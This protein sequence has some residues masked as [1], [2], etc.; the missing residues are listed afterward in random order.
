M[1]LAQII[2]STGMY[3][4]MVVALTHRLD[5]INRITLAAYHAWTRPRRD[6]WMMADSVSELG[7]LFRSIVSQVLEPL[8]ILFRE[9]RQQHEEV[10]RSQ[11]DEESIRILLQVEIVIASL[12]RTLIIICE[13]QSSET[14]LL[15][16]TGLFYL[17]VRIFDE[18]LLPMHL[19]PECDEDVVHLVAGLLTL[20]QIFRTLEHVN[21]VPAIQDQLLS[22]LLVHDMHSYL[23]AGNQGTEQEEECRVA[24]QR[25]GIAFYYL[26]LR[27][28]KCPSA[29]EGSLS[30]AMLKLHVG[31]VLV[32]FWS[33][34]GS[35]L[36]DC[37]AKDPPPTLLRMFGSIRRFFAIYVNFSNRPP[38]K[39]AK[40]TL[41]GASSV[42]SAVLSMLN[43]LWEMLDIVVPLLKPCDRKEPLIEWEGYQNLKRVIGK[44]LFQVE[45][46]QAGT[47]WQGQ[48]Q[49]TR[50]FKTM[51]SNIRVLSIQLDVDD[52]YILED[53]SDL[54]TSLWEA[55]HDLMDRLFLPSPETALSNTMNQ[56]GVD[57]Q[58][59]WS[60]V[61][62]CAVEADDRV[63]GQ[64]GEYEDTKEDKQVMSQLGR[65]VSDILTLMRMA[66]YTI[67]H[68]GP[69]QG[70]QCR[71]LD[72]EFVS[73][74]MDL[75]D[76]QPVTDAA[77]TLRDL[78][79]V[80][81]APV[82]IPAPATTPTE[83]NEFTWSLN[84]LTRIR[85]ECVRAQARYRN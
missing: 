42:S 76:S 11:G 43:Y 50:F 51:W 68:E 9:M 61:A 12:L 26:Q 44:L 79:V 73:W 27:F 47:V 46:C 21:L 23:G 65:A 37:I 28:H 67:V 33:H 78:S 52:E 48:H 14:H 38:W 71:Q 19:S 7:I 30:R 80:A 25:W 85:E 18:A 72:L 1:H 24:C 5:T 6:S 10:G 20:F 45:Q 60:C 32:W 39:R 77:Q 82:T 29:E 2:E 16:F 64:Q 54:L 69:K 3:D 49:L 40:S 13:N 66:R 8:W 83:S 58:E 53:Q 31:E 4:D 36:K 56:H 17:V 81:L 15:E 55:V 63:Q 75:I 62:D 34:D 59:T 57:W 22:G 35:S 70:H 84:E 74:I 41:V